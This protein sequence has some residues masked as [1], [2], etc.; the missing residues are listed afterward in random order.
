MY[1]N[2]RRISALNKSIKIMDKRNKT[3][4]MLIVGIC[5][6]VLFLAIV[7]ICPNGIKPIPS[8]TPTPKLLER[9]N[10]EQSLDYLLE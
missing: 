5:G 10:V 6:I 4:I 9:M 2:P 8:P 3:T 7:T 1:Y